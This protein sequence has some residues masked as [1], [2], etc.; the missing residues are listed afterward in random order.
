MTYTEALEYLASFVNYENIP[1]WPY[2][3]SLKLNRFKE[4]LN[5]LGNPQYH[6]RC[7]HIAGTKGK[8]STC[9]FIA[10]ILKEAGFKVGL[11]TSPHLA[12]FRER[13]RILDKG[14]SYPKGTPG[15][16]GMI[17]PRDLTALV[18]KIKPYI[19]SFDHKSKYG[20]LSFFE[21]YTALA[22]LYFQKKG[23]DF[24]VLE[25]GLGGRL[26]ATNTAHPLICVITPISYEHTQK[27]GNTLKKIAAEKSGI[28]KKGLRQL[29]V[30]S[31]PQT[32]EAD[33]VIRAR[34]RKMRAKF[35]QA[36]NGIRYRCKNNH[37]NIKGFFE[38]YRG[39]KIKLIGKH[40]VI[41]AAVAAAAVELL[42]FYNIR[43]SSFQI[44]K[45]LYHTI[46][47]GRCEIIMR[48]P[49][50]VIDGAQNR[51]SALVLREALRN[52]FKYRRLILVLGISKDKDIAGI[53]SELHDLA[54]KVI[55]TRADNLR[56][57]APRDLA[58]YFLDK[59][60]FITDNV[61]EAKREAL[62]LAGKED[63]ILVCGSLFVVGEFRN[64]KL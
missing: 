43:I 5:G 3:Q 25:T 26:D 36:G 62:L 51:A 52:N 27:L 35:Y 53:S 7:I 29:I 58:G 34:C 20:G 45:G 44:K 46:W 59:E 64:D 57:S 63:L 37:F 50:V 15:F 28:I 41:N 48:N 9:A 23:A 33:K 39:L 16:E 11:Y 17:S 49:C 42:R 61:R 19:A 56:A 22:F 54:D 21:V 24:V 8:G 31:A 32:R 14:V 12:D 6:L 18:A 10:H 55:L 2:K 13:I 38:I 40:Q 60:L 4:F 30:V 47:P 1:S